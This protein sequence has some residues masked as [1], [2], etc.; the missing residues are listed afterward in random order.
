MGPTKRATARSILPGVLFCLALA[1]LSIAAWTVYKPISGMMWAFITSIVFVNLLGVPESLRAGV[2][3]CSNQLLK[4][5]VALLGIVTSAL[6]WGEVGVGVVNALA[7]IAFSLVLSLWLGGRLGLSRRLSALIGA[8]TAVCGASAIAALAPVVGSKEEETGLAISGITL[9]GLASMFLYPYLFLN[10]AVG[11][12]LAQN[13]NV[14]AIWAGSGIHETAQVIAAA[15]ALGSEVAKPAMLIKSVRIF[16]IGPIVFFFSSLL[17]KGSVGRKTKF[18]VP[19]FAVA[20]VVNSLLCAAL[21]SYA[22]ALAAAG[23]DWVLVK[24]ILSGWVIPF[25]LATAFVGVG[26]KVRLKSI[27]ALGARPLAVAATVAVAA[28]AVSLMMA[29]LVAP[30]IPV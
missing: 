3:F 24:S 15:G 23:F 10:T 28:G 16:M 4:V 25:L 8:G 12:W 5:A 30:M 20:F 27:A 18:V 13:S 11:G 26:S 29:A 19:L 2:A 7:V 17:S 6:I 14:Y 9:F 1:A 22:P 21:D